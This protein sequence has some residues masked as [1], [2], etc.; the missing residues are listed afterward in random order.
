MNN[1]TRISVFVFL[2]FCSVSMNAQQ[3]K[4]YQLYTSS[5]APIDYNQMLESVSKSDFIFFGELHN[6]AIAHWLQI[7]L[8]QDLYK[9]TGDKLVLAAEM[10]ESDNQ[11]ILDEY[12]SGLISKSRFEAECRLWPNYKNDY[13]PLVE[14]AKEKKIPFVAS[15]V[16][17]RYASLVSQKGFEGL[18][19]VSGEGQAFFPPLP[20]EYD[21]EVPCY[22]EMLNMGGGMMGGGHGNENLPKA[23]ALKDAAM[24]FFSLKYFVTGNQVLHFNGAYHSQ[25]HEGIIW[26]VNLY[27][28]GLDIKVIHTV[29]QADV[30]QLE[31]DNKGLGD[32]IL[33][34]D[35][36]VTTTY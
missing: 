33:V 3:K 7:E 21:P 6:N 17:R 9:N 23:Q 5:G 8:T 34:V 32:F 14:F 20:I 15:N 28:P 25:N 1:M 4:A 24:A 26:Y 10:F 22:K 36:D 16:P 12:L 13:M 35:E 2:L 29:T 18:D 11:V 27:N 31:E 19:S 30:Y